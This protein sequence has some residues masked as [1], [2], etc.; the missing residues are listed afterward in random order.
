MCTLETLLQSRATT[1]LWSHV[2]YFM[3]VH[4]L[5]GTPTYSIF[6]LWEGNSAGHLRQSLKLTKKFTKRHATAETKKLESI[7]QFIIVILLVTL[8]DDLESI[9]QWLELTWG[10]ITICDN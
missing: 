8:L 10:R 1:L 6:H 4:I 9:L 5:Q 2:T 7:Q 3:I